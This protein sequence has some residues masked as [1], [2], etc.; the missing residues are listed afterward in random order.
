MKITIDLDGV[1]S[2][3]EEDDG[4]TS[5]SLTELFLRCAVGAGFAHSS[6]VDSM[7]DVAYNESPE[8]NE[9]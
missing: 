7:K 9:S 3:V 5:Y 1:K 2:M 4:V 8:R 6:V